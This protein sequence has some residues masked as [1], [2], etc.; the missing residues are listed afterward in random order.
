MGSIKDVS[1]VHVKIPLNVHYVFG[2]GTMTAFES[3]I[4]RIVTDDGIEGYGESIPLFRSTK[5]DPT[6]VARIVNGPVRESLTGKDPFDIERIVEEVLDISGGNVDVPAGV[7]PALWDIMG[8]SLGQ[9]VYK[10]LGG[11][12]Q[13]PIPVDHTI[14]GSEPTAMAEEA[15]QA[16]EKGF[17]GVVVKVDAESI[18]KDVQRVRSVRDVLPAGCTVRVDCNGAF[19]RDTA[20]QF[21]ES[22]AEMDIEFVE[23][24][25]E[26]TDIEGL[27]MCRTVGVP[28]SVDESVITVRD[29]LEVVS[30]DACDIMNIKV[31]RV[32]GLLL[33]K[34]MAAVA[35]AAG[36]PVVV[37]GRTALQLS[38]YTSR[39]L[40]A[41]TPGS[42][43]RK[44]E[45][46]G[47]LSQALSDD[48]VTNW[49]TQENG[50][51][52][53]ERSPGMGYE[54]VWDKVQRYAMSS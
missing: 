16:L 17:R 46:P 22:I 34:R 14:G 20:K 9:P 24:P 27:R 5:S 6:S 28:I 2:R 53:V 26:A 35:A 52:R 40:A 19:S 8:K 44:H 41:S 29:A 50:Y 51:V 13:D 36:V 31:P 4:V 33:A 10:L 25:V 54:I 30:R 15:R 1:A 3:V 11:L 32:G 37:G 12:C 42:M 18:E 23:Q 38:R 7:D 21:L 48:V 43:G 49:T 47:P 39:H 45:G